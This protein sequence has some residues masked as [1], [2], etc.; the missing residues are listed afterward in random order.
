MAYNILGVNPGHN[1]SVALL[2]DGKLIYYVEEERLSRLKY[3]GNPFKSINDI[4]MK[5]HV[6][7]IVIA[8]TTDN[9]PKLPWTGE[10]PYYALVRKY[11]KNVKLTL[12][13]Q[14][15]HLTH[16]CV[17][18]YNSGFDKALC[19]VVDGAGSYVTEKIKNGDDEIE[20]QGF[21]S[22]S[23]W[24]LE[25][26][27]QVSLLHKNYGNNF[28]FKYFDNLFSFDNATTITK[29]YEGITHYL[30]FGFIEAGKTMGLSSY[31]KND[32]NIPN[33]FIEDRGSKDVFIPNY[34]AG[35][36]VDI[37]RFP[38][39]QININNDEWHKDPNKTPEI[40]K[41]MAWKIQNDTQKLVGDLIE[42]YH[43]IT[44]IEKIILCG[45]YALNCVA[46]YYYK[47]RFPSL[48]IYVEPISHDGG[49]SIGAAKAIWWKKQSINIQTNENE[50]DCFEKDIQKTLYYGPTYSLD[51]I[52]NNLNK[53]IGEKYE[54]K[55]VSYEDVAH[56]LKDRKIVALYQGKSEAGPRALGNRSILYDPTDENGK[57]H[58]NKVKGREWFRPFAGSVLAE[59]ANEWFDMAGMVESPFMM[60]AVN[61]VADKIKKIPA[62]THVD[63]TCRIQTVTEEQNKHFYNLIKSFRNLTGVPI[64]FNTSFNL[65]GDPLVETIDDAF[66]AL[67]KSDIDYLYLPEL[68]SLIIKK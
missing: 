22:E 35:S 62:I 8:G 11:N 39:L 21:E 38:Q 42:K 37:A 28:G 47:K 7:E 60:Y 55:K 5:W 56:I 34:P 66:D 45:G 52:Q 53:Y 63:D 67:N 32:P 6:D 33:F 24:V 49:T 26:P 9:L 15:H 54:I 58:V 40:A 44:G 13:G 12:L 10:N 41:N 36:F 19:I 1:G 43:N 17:S 29:S 64:L 59:E 51:E 14:E 30:G 23:V 27:F 2:S 48:E 18:F 61:V 16:A 57:N 65:A 50:K 46:N 4:L 25:Y 31:G 68:E 3:D 20:M